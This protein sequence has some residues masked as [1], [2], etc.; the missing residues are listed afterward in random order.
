MKCATSFIKTNDEGKIESLNQIEF[1]TFYSQYMND[2]TDEKSKQ[3]GI[4]L[5]E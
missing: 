4:D 2:C 1:Q 5:F 3:F